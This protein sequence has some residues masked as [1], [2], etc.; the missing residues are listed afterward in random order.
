MFCGSASFFVILNTIVVKNTQNMQKGMVITMLLAV[1][2]AIRYFVFSLY[3]AGL[4]SFP[5]PL[6]A[7]A[8]RECLERIRNG[9]KS[10]KNQL[11]EHNLRL[12]VH[13]IKKYYS[14]QSDQDDLISIGTIGLIKAANTFDY[15][16]GTR[17][18]TYGA[19]CIE[20]EI[21]MFFRAK[22]KTSLEWYISEAIDT[23]N[24]G[25][26]LTLGEVMRDEDNMFDIVEKKLRGE[27]LRAAIGT[28]L[29]PRE[30]E[31]ILLRY[32]LGGKKE[33]TQREVSTRLGISRSY[34]PVNIGQKTFEVCLI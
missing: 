26:T 23:D 21:L 10:A 1:I 18:A 11:I 7:K 28:E 4:G 2:G 20:N 13:I 34:G 12:V 33:L 30:R 15:E 25:N 5:K 19:R 24:D 29:E 14:A 6:S 9:D 16:K 17:F 22:K 31:I 3:V 27:Q 32:G 8:E